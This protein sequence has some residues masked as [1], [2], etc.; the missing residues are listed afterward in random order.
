MAIKVVFFDMPTSNKTGENSF[1][2]QSSRSEKSRIT[3]MWY[4]LEDGGKLSSY[5]ILK[6][7]MV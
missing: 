4:I 2:I 5:I 7:K 1:L 6:R 3:V